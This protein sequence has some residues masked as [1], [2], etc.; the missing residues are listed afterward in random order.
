MTDEQIVLS[1]FAGSVLVI[2]SLAVYFV[3]KINKGF[4]RD[5]V[6]FELKQNNNAV[7][8][9][10]VFLAVC[11]ILII[12][13]PVEL[14]TGLL[15]F[16]SGAIVCGYLVFLSRLR[17]GVT[18]KGVYLPG[19]FIGFESVQDYY[20]DTEKSTIIFSK[21]PK[22]GLSTS[23]ITPP[24]KYRKEDEKLI[25]EFFDGLIAERGSKIVVR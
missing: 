19:R 11:L 18:E 22:G 23:G 12:F 17:F 1:I 5:G 24:L 2:F 8:Y 10:L 4:K 21:H 3:L 13:L 16:L 25:I 9:A 15:I 20:M 14:L 6:L 7:I